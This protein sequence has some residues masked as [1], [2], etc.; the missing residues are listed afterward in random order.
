[1]MKKKIKIGY[2][3]VDIQLIDKKLFPKWSTEHLG[4]YDANNQVIRILAKQR[5]SEELNTLFHEVIHAAVQVSGLNTDKG[6]LK[7]MVDEE[8]VVSVLANTLQ[9]IFRD[10][11]W[12]LPYVIKQIGAD[13]IDSKTRAKTFSRL[14]KAAR[15][16]RTQ[17]DERLKLFEGSGTGDVGT[18]SPVMELPFPL[19]ASRHNS[20][21]PA[22]RSVFPF[23]EIF[24]FIKDKHRL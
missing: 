24:D 12:F 3:D 19:P 8:Q 16:Q 20:P 4:D 9:Q 2:A 1:M 22:S 7:K 10:N 11:N 13:K 5:P 17:K 6:P 14:K 18:W 21:V 15:K 23:V